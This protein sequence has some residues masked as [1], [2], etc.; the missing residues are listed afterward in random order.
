MRSAYSVAMVVLIACS[1][2]RSVGRRRFI[3]RPPPADAGAFVIP[4]EGQ[5]EIPADWTECITDD[6]CTIVTLGCCDETPVNRKH[7]DALRRA[8]EASGR[9]SCP[10]KTACG[11]GEDGTW[12]GVRSTCDAATCRMP[13]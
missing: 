5:F 8:L 9:P 11:P 7:A 10:P 4:R 13:R 12:D 3:D 1:S 2:R 6:D